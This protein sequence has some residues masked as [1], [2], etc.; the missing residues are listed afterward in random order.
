M[1]IQIDGQDA[2]GTQILDML[3]VYGKSVS[4]LFFGFFE[5][6]RSVISRP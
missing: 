1:P 4:T 3:Q 2:M 5:K 6:V